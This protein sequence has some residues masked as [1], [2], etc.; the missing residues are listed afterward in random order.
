MVGIGPDITGKFHP[1]VI[2]TLQGVGAWLAVNGEAIYGTRPW[3]LF[4]EGPTEVAEGAFTDTNRTAFTGED[5]RFT[6]KGDVLYA[7]LLAWPESGIATIRSLGRSTGL[8]TGEIHTITLL[9]DN[10]ESLAFTQGDDALTVTLPETKPC[11]HAFVLK[12][13]AG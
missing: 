2:L 7:I 10:N 6:T 9:G 8:Y 4:G 13:T 11:D 12:I 3:K 5:V 1:K